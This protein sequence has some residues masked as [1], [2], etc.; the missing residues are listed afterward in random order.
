MVRCGVLVTST[1]VSASRAS[2]TVVAV[3]PLRVSVP[4]KGLAALAWLMP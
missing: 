3:A 4:A 2:I 1:V